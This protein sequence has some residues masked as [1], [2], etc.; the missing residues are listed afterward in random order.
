M[1]H[2][3]EIG[4]RQGV[5]DAHGEGV[6]E[7]IR[8][9]LGLPVETA[10]TRTVYKVH[11]GL[12]PAEAEAVRREF[13]DPVVERSAV[14]RLDAP[15]FD[16]M[17]TVGYKP[18]VTDNVGRTSKTAVEDILGRHLPD[19]DAVYTERQFLLTGAD[20]GRSDVRRIGTDLLA[21]ELI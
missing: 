2:R 16:W 11:A 3:I 19:S 20:L 8:A 17:L 15:P 12:T 9:F 7:S 10:Q 13:T 14:G 5:R 6:A 21:N 4:Y 1:V 18:G